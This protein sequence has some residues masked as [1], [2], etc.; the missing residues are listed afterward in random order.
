M[1]AYSIAM[2]Y[3]ELKQPGAAENLVLADGPVPQA[4]PGELLIRVAAAG[5]NRPDVLQRRGLYPP[6]PDASPVLGL[7]VAGEVAAIGD[8]VEGWRI[9]DPV[10]ALTPGGGYA[11]YCTAPAPQCLPIPPGLSAAEAAA[12]PE[13]LFTVWGNLFERGRLAAGES[14]LIHGG[15]SGIG[16][17]AIQLAKAFGANVFTTARNAEKCAAC[18]ALGADVAIRYTDQDYAA[19]IAEKT[20][21]RG[22]DVILDMVGGATVERSIASLAPD[23]RLVFIAFLGGSKTPL[24]LLP[25]M[26]KRLTIT[27]STLRPQSIAAKAR[28]AAAL[29]AQVWP[30]ITAGR[31]RPRIHRRF[32]LAAAAEAH[33]LLEGGEVI[34]KLVLE[35]A[36]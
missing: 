4:K 32:P 35:V 26:T 10:C 36:A 14:V 30:L 9:G 23:G 17:T 22:V 25:I 29:Q 21:G 31:F 8:G 6:P 19:I 13:T 24:D 20:A 1:S 11:E 5:I 18:V 16:T 34:G 28:I 2:K 7:E 12:L 33:R 15:A 27:G 3:I